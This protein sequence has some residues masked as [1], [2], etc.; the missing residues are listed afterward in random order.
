MIV[1]LSGYA[2]F[3][4]LWCAVYTVFNGI[5]RGLNNLPKQIKCGKPLWIELKS[6]HSM[7]YYYL[8]LVSAGLN[9]IHII[10]CSKTHYDQVSVFLKY[11]SKRSNCQ[12][13]GITL[14][15]LQCFQ[16]SLMRSAICF[17]STNKES[18]FLLVFASA[19]KG[20]D[21]IRRGCEHQSS[22]LLWSPTVNLISYKWCFQRKAAK[23]GSPFSQNHPCEQF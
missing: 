13:D 3:T 16:C 8:G 19:Y 21:V 11:V 15:C 9:Y 22:I 4:A 20:S 7:I 2:T 5:K 18:N 1:T 10:K 17:L 14:F 6:G 23:L 12:Q